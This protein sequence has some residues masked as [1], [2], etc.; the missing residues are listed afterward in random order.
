MLQTD[1]QAK[2]NQARKAGD[3]EAVILL[4]VILG[5]LSTLKARNN[6]EP[7]EEQVENVIRSLRNKNDDVLAG[8]DIDEEIK[9]QTD[10]NRVKELQALKVSRLQDRS[11]TF[12]KLRREN[13]FFTTMLPTTLTVEEIKVILAEI[14]DDLLAAKAGAAVGV[15]MKFLK[16]K[17][18]KVLGDDVKVAVEQLKQ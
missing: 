12:E 10:E 3:K 1:V 6:K 13:A 17:G 14:R 15:A 16:P 2:L 5:D 11:D 9:K 8:K 7:T 4:S 18:L